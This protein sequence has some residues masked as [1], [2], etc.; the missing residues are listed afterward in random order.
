MAGA[1][2]SHRSCACSMRPC[3]KLLPA[4]A[5]EEPPWALVRSLTPS[6]ISLM[7]KTNAHCSDELAAWLKLPHEVN[8]HCGTG[9][10]PFGASQVPSNEPPSPTLYLD[11]TGAPFQ[12]IRHVGFHETAPHFSETRSPLLQDGHLCADFM[13]EHKQMPAAFSHFLL[14]GR[15]VQVAEDMSCIEAAAV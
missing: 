15:H 5:L 12:A 3:R 9:C 2:A 10:G 6:A 8:L 7:H 14:A 11:R 13:E 1:R 4:P